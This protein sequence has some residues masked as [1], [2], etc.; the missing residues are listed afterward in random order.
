MYIWDNL[1]V[2]V[3][4]LNVSC[5]IYTMYVM[6]NYVDSSPNQVKRKIIQMVFVASPLITQH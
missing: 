4:V 1:C 3:Y 2:C 6:H 5:F